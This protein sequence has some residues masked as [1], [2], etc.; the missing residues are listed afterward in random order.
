MY[1]IANMTGKYIVK[2]T[3]NQFLFLLFFFIYSSVKTRHLI[4]MAPSLCT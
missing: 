3:I 1:D 4:E 2:C